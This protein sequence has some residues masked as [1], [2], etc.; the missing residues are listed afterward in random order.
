MR[1]LVQVFR[2]LPALCGT[3]TGQ[4][5]AIQPDVHLSL[6]VVKV[7]ASTPAGKNHMG[8][9]VIIAPNKIATNCHVTREASRISVTKSGESYKVIKQAALP[10]YDVC[11]LESTAL[12]LPNASLADKD[13]L[14]IG[15]EIY[16]YG[17]PYALGMRSMPG[18]VV[19]LH[20][21]GEAPVIE[22]DAGFMQGASGGGIFNG[23]GEL[24]GLTT[25]MGRD[26][27]QFHF[28]AI[29][30]EWLAKALH[31]PFMP[32][33]AFQQLSFWENGSFV[34]NQSPD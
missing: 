12:P 22:I 17:F 33:H 19:A 9:G 24:V 4:V 32:V 15:S 25:F 16:L 20:R 3:Y 27:K 18:S 13:S 31:E 23:K 30:A 21:H 6:S 5:P 26:G 7:I 11:I 14:T 8:S 34:R 29:P 2:Y 28:Y 10:E 1:G